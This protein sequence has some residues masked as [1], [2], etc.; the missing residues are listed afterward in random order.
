MSFKLSWITNAQLKSTLF[1]KYIIFNN[2]NSLLFSDDLYI[3][4]EICAMHYKEIPSVLMSK[5]VTNITNYVNHF[6]Y[7]PH[8]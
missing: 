6:H 4:V 2:L 3:Q 8:E 1:L 5:A 7:M